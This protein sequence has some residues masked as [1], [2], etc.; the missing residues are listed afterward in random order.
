MNKR[1]Q[2]KKLSKALKR[3]AIVNKSINLLTQG[4]RNGKNYITKTLLSIVEESSYGR[5]KR[6]EKML[7]N[8]DEKKMRK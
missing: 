2:K 4:R 6:L 8:K 3:V 7:K 1:Q 5:F